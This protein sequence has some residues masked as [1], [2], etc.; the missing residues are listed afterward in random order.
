LFTVIVP[1]AVDIT[2]VAAVTV[3]PVVIACSSPPFEAGGNRTATRTK[4]TKTAAQVASDVSSFLNK[5]F[6]VMMGNKSSAAN[7]KN[8]MKV[9]PV[10]SKITLRTASSPHAPQKSSASLS[11][12]DFAA[13]GCG[14]M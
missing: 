3:L 13:G 11:S 2:S 6:L 5:I 14:C 8:R 9:I 12:D 10:I 1:P 7:P 4:T